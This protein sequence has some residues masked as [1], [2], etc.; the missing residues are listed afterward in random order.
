MTAMLLLTSL[1]IKR[2]TG[3][4]LQRM[5][6]EGRRGGKLLQ[7][8]AWQLL[9]RKKTRMWTGRRRWRRRSRKRRRRRKRR[10]RIGRGKES[11]FCAAGLRGELKREGDEEVVTLVTVLVLEEE[12]EVENEEEEEDEEEEEEEEDEEE[13][14][15]GSRS[16]EGKTL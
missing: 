14:E 12:E 11:S 6:V 15:E 7:W 16:G 10:K 2:T 4:L 1:L 8:M 13:V 5:E 9:A 3:C